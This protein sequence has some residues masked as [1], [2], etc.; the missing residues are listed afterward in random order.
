MSRGP[1]VLEY[2]NTAYSDRCFACLPAFYWSS[3]YALF[4]CKYQVKHVI[5]VLHDSGPYNDDILKEF[6]P[7]QEDNK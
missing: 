7:E 1:Q 4:S 6:A 3:N 2:E 5:K